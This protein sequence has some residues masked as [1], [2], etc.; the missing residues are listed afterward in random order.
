MIIVKFVIQDRKVIDYMS[1][2]SQSTVSDAQMMVNA[3][4]P[5]V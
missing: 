5:L 4:G 1:L 2:I 3:C